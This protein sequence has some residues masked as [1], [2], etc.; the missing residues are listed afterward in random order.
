MP[1]PESLER[2]VVH[3]PGWRVFERHGSLRVKFNHQPDG[4]TLERLRSFMQWDNALRE[5]FCPFN[6]NLRRHLL[7]VAK[8]AQTW[9]SVGETPPSVWDDC[10]DPGGWGGD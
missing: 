2:N 6:T 3:G 5:W 7:V 10:E 8:H 9:E 4:R 1:T